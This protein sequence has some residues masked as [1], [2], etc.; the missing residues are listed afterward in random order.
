M[1]TDKNK[2]K[3]L[4]GAVAGVAGATVLPASAKISTDNVPPTISSESSLS[5]LEVGSLFWHDKKLYVKLS[6]TE[7]D[8]VYPAIARYA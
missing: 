3:F 2:R 7:I 1:T 6:N 8:Q 5:E 4:K